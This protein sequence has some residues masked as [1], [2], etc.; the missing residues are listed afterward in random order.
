MEGSKGDLEVNETNEVFIPSLSNSHTKY[1]NTI[2]SVCLSISLHIILIVGFLF[3]NIISG[4]LCISIIGM[5]PT[6]SSNSVTSECDRNSN[7][8]LV[9]NPCVYILT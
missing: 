3:H 9:V 6:T 2:F 4:Y 7:K 8:D 5:I 1:I